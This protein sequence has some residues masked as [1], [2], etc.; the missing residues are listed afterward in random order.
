MAKRKASSDTDTKRIFE[1]GILSRN[2]VLVYAIG[3]CPLIAVAKSAATACVLAILSAILL[4]ALE[5]LTALILKKMPK[6]LRVGVYAL[7]GVLIIIPFYMLMGNYMP[8]IE[9]SLG[10]YIPLLAVNSLNVQRCEAF[11]VKHSVKQSFFDAVANSIG[12]AIPLIL[13]GILREA[14]G[15]S[16]I[17]GYYIDALPQADGFLMPFC[18]F[19]ILGFVAAFINFIR[20]KFKIGEEFDAKGNDFVLD[21]QK[22]K[23]LY[24]NDNNDEDSLQNEITVV[25]ETVQETNAV[26]AAKDNAI[27]SSAET[28]S[29]ANFE[30]SVSRIMHKW[31]SENSNET[32]ID[33]KAGAEKVETSSKSTIKNSDDNPIPV[34]LSEKSTSSTAPTNKKISE[35]VSDDVESISSPVDN[36]TIE[37]AMQTTVSTPANG[38][39]IPK[40]TTRKRTTKK[41]AEAK[42]ETIDAALTSANASTTENTA[43]TAATDAS[44]APAPKK[45]TRKRT[46]KKAADTKAETTDTA[47]TTA[48][49]SAAETAPQTAATDVPEAPVPKKTTRK[50]TTK[51]AAEAKAETTDT[52]LTSTNAPAAETTAQTAATGT[53][54]APA[55]KK[56]TRKRT[57]KKATETK[58]ETT[59]AALNSTNAPAAETAPHIAATDVSE[60]PTPK[61]TTRKRT[62]KKAAEAKAETTDAALTTADA[63]AAETAPQI[64]ATDVSEAPAPK[65]TTRKRTT[66]KAAETKAE[67]TDA[68][69]TSANAPA[70][71]TTGQTVSADTSEAPAPKKTTRKRTTKKT[72][73]ATE[74]SD[75]TST[76]TNKSETAEAVSKAEEV[77][78]PKK[79]TRKRTSSKTTKAAEP[80]QETMPKED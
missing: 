36:S 35:I 32:A 34:S 48:D 63:P 33:F 72:A 5:T 53:L 44:E 29:S 41:T 20:S 42:A 50:R 61:K 3:I 77:S 21:K 46:T 37:A 47:L 7:L 56:T 54:E 75:L 4:I 40:K 76:D 49:A 27:P 39:A 68:T 45:T 80:K 2:P 66:K 13:T 78:A 26:S 55:P 9:V 30:S 51:K 65:K 11:A 64:A 22:D 59:D 60:A 28:E 24:N 19:I 8:S 52:A 15:S 6:W 71:E 16:R 14:L 70:A 38:T 58:A 10:I 69:F 62:T 18:G 12:Y 23:A 43:Q 79:T 73:E 17:F 67:A 74:K 31:A 57:T 1:K 25:P